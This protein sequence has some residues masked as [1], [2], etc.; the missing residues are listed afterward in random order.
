MPI[1]PPETRASLIL[2]LPD[3]ADIAAW[4]EFVAIYQPLLRRMATRQG[5][6]P[7]DADDVLQEVFSAVAK[8][9]SQWLTRED[10]GSFRAWLLR[11]A[12]NA[13]VHQLTR[14]RTRPLAT[15]GDDVR[16]FFDTLPAPAGPLSSEFDV[17]Y[18]QEVFRWA[19]ARVRASVSESTWQAFWLT[20]VEG[21]SLDAAATRLG[22]TLGNLYIARSRVMARLRESVRQFEVRS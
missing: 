9:V 18:R 12:R 19:A 21:V 16:N 10:R 6:Q 3:P 13:A 20:H 4:D 8:S 5:L 11:I 7:A 14:R 1:S 17:E 22:M 15:G 2:R